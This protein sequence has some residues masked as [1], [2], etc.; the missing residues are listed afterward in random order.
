MTIQAFEKALKA[1]PFR[2]FVLHMANGRTHRV[3]H[4]DYVARSPA[5]RTVTVYD[6]D[7]GASVLDVLLINEIEIET[8]EREEAA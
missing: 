2:P 5:G 7:E 8:P 1:D 3:W 6:D 4:R